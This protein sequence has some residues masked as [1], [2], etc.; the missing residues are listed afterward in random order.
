MDNYRTS[1]FNKSAVSNININRV[2]PFTENSAQCAMARLWDTLGLK[3]RQPPKC[4]KLRKT[5]QQYKTMPQAALSA[6][7]VAK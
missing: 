2:K 7:H 4:S 5:Q 6:N 1:L 3:V